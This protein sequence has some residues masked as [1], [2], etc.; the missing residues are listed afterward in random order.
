LEIT[1]EPSWILVVRFSK[2]PS[3]RPLL[4]L[5]RMNRRVWQNTIEKIA[6]SR[7]KIATSQRK[8]VI[9]VGFAFQIARSTLQLGE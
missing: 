2:T 8:N 9:Q 3:L 6:D 4:G 1:V 5:G 7:R